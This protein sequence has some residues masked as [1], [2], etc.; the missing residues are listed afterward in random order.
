MTANLSQLSEDDLLDL[1]RDGNVRAYGELYDRFLDEIYRY[2][3]FR[4]ARNQLEAEDLAQEVFL[5]AWDVISRPKKSSKKDNFRALLYRISHNLAVDRWRGHKEQVA[6]DEENPPA[7]ASAG[8]L[9]EAK[10]VAQEQSLML[11]EAVR[12]LEPKL[13]EVFICRFI[14]NLSHAETAQVLGLK[15]GHVR[16]LQHRALKKIRVEIE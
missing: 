13:Q 2:L 7:A 10:L 16:V 8:E 15:E 5:K 1:V 14:N 4:V 9:P 3:F 12:E 11:A 6:W